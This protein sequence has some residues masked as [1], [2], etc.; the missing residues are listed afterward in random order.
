[1]IKNDVFWGLGTL[2]VSFWNIFYPTCRDFRSYS[3]LY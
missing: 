2:S 3:R 1:M